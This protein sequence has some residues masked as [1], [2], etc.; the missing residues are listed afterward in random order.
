[1]NNN[2]P[3]LGLR[4]YTENDRIYGRDKE[5]VQLANFIKSNL[6]TIIYGKSGV[7]K[8]SLLQAGVFPLLRDEDMFPVYMRLEHNSEKS[9][10]EQ[11]KDAVLAASSF[12]IES[13]EN[14]GN[15]LKKFLAE[16]NFIDDDIRCR[17]YPV[18]V[19][20][21]FEEIFTLTDTAHKHDVAS[22]FDYIADVLDVQEPCFRIVICLREDYLYYLEQNSVRIPDLKRNRFSLKALNKEQAT[23]IITRPC[24]GIVIA[25]VVERILNK[26]S[27]KNADEYEPAILSLFMFSLYEKMK[28]S[29]LGVISN[30][31]VNTF[32][33]NIISDFY[34]SA[35][36]SIS[37]S[38]MEFIE[39]HLL[40]DGGYR[41]N[42]PVDDARKH[43]VT[44]AEIKKLVDNRI[45]T[46][47]PRFNNI[48]YLEYSHDILCAVAV[49]SRNERRLRIQKKMNRRRMRMI[50]GLAVIVAVI[51]ISV[52]II[53]LMINQKQFLEQQNNDMLRM[54]SR[55][56][57]YIAQ[58]NMN[59]NDHIALIAALIEVIPDNS[60]EKNKRPFDGSPIQQLYNIED[61]ISFWLP[62]DA[63]VDYFS[64]EGDTLFVCTNGE[65]NYWYNIKD[66]E[67]IKVEEIKGR[68]NSINKNMDVNFY[69]TTIVAKKE[70]IKCLKNN[71]G[72]KIEEIIKYSRNNPDSHGTVAD[73]TKKDVQKAGK[74]NGAN[75]RYTVKLSTDKKIIYVLCNP[76]DSVIH[77]NNGMSS[78]DVKNELQKKIRHEKNHVSFSPDGSYVATVSK[79]K[80]VIIWN[81]ADG[82]P[83]IINQI[84]HD[85]YV[86]DVSY[87]FDG[88]YG[89]TASSDGTARIWDSTLKC[90]DTLSHAC[91]VKSASFSPDGNC[92]VT[93]SNDTVWIWDVINGKGYL[94]DS[95][96]D[97]TKIISASFS[98]DGDF[99]ITVSNNIVKIC[100]AKKKYCVCDS[101]Q[102]DSGFKTAT[103][104]PD[105][106]YIMTSSIDGMVEIWDFATRECIWVN[107]GNYISMSPDMKTIAI[108]KDNEVIVKPFIKHEELIMKYR[109]MIEGYKLSP[110]N[111]KKY[112]LD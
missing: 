106:R 40:T 13:S 71:P 73:V 70:I 105:G 33:D 60:D 100:N 103:F 32:G 45:V 77:L 78:E 83:V 85:D 108:V 68:I 97:G 88:S 93:V 15:S 11:I 30:E 42:I 17:Q 24:H 19:F 29:G 22:F 112:F 27:L 64:I 81:V 37:D 58:E 2:N 94:T 5:K 55:A 43:G 53:A 104:S 109:K 72:K 8:S 65:K 110:E 74:L 18:L 48:E 59:G 96:K 57:A 46:I 4:T 89:V 1:M 25:D 47:T 3:W 31:L 34:S 36:K 6:H 86:N 21:Q 26:V 63:C 91:E 14:I 82:K 7:G 66:K 69:D 41:H 54:Q 95:I 98:P 28:S 12:R 39:E 80:T 56:T 99:L 61:L 84:I 23:E 50:V 75:S 10:L 107:N 52:G 20:D 62:F 67:T 35:T 16:T 111:R 87:S 102:Y 92:I 101:L 9:Y 76:N 44:S 79:G 51:I 49:K 38:S 90:I